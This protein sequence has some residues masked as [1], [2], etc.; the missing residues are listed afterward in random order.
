[1]MIVMICFV[2]V[3]NAGENCRK[4]GHVLRCDRYDAEVIQQATVE[5]VYLGYCPLIQFFPNL[6]HVINR[7]IIERTPMTCNSFHHQTD[8]VIFLNGKQCQKS[9]VA[10]RHQTNPS[11]PMTTSSVAVE[12]II[13]TMNRTWLYVSFG[14]IA[15]IVVLCA[16]CCVRM[17]MKRRKRNEE[18]TLNYH[19]GD[20]ESVTEFELGALKND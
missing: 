8:T 11:S 2:C 5:V 9:T 20:L 15:V 3:V 18:R 13:V 1:M 14:L 19:I 10:S 17:M 12:T 6:G 16:V 7:L 4:T